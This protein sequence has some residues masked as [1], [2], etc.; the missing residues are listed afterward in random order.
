[1]RVNSLEQLEKTYHRV[2]EEMAG[3]RIVDGALVQGNHANDGVS[4]WQ[5]RQIFCLFSSQ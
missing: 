1:M 2:Q 4:S 5:H 3:A